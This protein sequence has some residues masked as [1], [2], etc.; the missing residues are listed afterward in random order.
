MAIA[1]SEAAEAHPIEVAVVR[2]FTLTGARHL[3]GKASYQAARKPI[4]NE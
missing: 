3:D 1:L 2:F 4:P